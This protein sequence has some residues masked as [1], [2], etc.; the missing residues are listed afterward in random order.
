MAAALGYG[1]M[2][3]LM[4]ATPLAMQQCGLDFGATAMVLQWHVIGMFAPGF[5]TGDFIKRWGALPVMGV[6]VLLN[7]AC[8]VVALSGVDVLQFS[9]A[10]FLLGVGWNF[11]FTGGTSLSLQAYAPH[12]KDRAQAVINF[13]VFAVMALTS[14]ASGALVTTSGWFWLNAL[15]LLPL[16]ATGLMLW[17]LHARARLAA[18]APALDA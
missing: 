11:L 5:F 15:S 10:L 3:L 8:V 7:A 13:A 14:F 9:V 18:P 6:G 16:G 17:W 4:A 12:E 1:V 2:N